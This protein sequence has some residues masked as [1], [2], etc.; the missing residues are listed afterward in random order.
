MQ[1]IKEDLGLRSRK[2]GDGDRW[3]WN[4]FLCQEFIF[5]CVLPKMM[6]MIRNQNYRAERGGA[7]GKERESSREME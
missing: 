3:E 4:G 2:N 1:Y 7:L 5:W 6:Q